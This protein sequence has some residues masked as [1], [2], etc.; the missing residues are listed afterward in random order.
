MPLQSSLLFVSKAGVEFFEVPHYKGR[1]QASVTNIR[2]GW[3]CLPRKNTS[4]FGKIG[5][6][7]EKKLFNIVMWF[8][9]YK[10][11]LAYSL[12]KDQISRSFFSSKLC[13]PSLI[14]V[15]EPLVDFFELSYC[16]VRLFAIP[17][18][19]NTDWRS[20]PQT[21]TLTYNGLEENA[22]LNCC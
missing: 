12:K 16:L 9:V 3:K 17:T 19:I 7:R 22:F 5:R 15:I 20:L 14:F 2:P 8:H 11:F 10:T 1:L 4:L 6:E 21:N 13:Q 18:I